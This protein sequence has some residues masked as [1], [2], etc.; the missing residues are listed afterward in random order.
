MRDVYSDPAGSSPSHM[1]QIFLE[2]QS[3][4][5]ILVAKKVGKKLQ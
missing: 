2:I 4:F 5:H 1:W 3:N